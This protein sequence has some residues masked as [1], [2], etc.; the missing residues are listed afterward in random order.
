MRE[1]LKTGLALMHAEGKLPKDVPNGKSVIPGVAINEAI[2]Y[3]NAISETIDAEEVYVAAPD[4]KTAACLPGTLFAVADALIPVDEALDFEDRGEY[5]KAEVVKALLAGG[6][7]AVLSQGK[8]HDGA[9]AITAAAVCQLAGGSAE[10][11][12]KAAG[13]ADANVLAGMSA[14][15]AVN[16]TFA[17]FGTAAPNGQR[18]CADEDFESDI[19]WRERRRA[20]DEE[21]RQKLAREYPENESRSTSDEEDYSGLDSIL[22]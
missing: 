10:D 9:R 13:Y 14:I 22:F 18:V 6:L 1:S 20:F 15:S 8:E 7:I 19:N 3:I 16:A 5:I 4:Q 2:T 17:D 11:C 21:C 12:V